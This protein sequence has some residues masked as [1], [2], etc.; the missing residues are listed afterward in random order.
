MK[1][2]CRGYLTSQL[3]SGDGVVASTSLLL[4]TVAAVCRHA[5]AVNNRKR[6][7][8]HVHPPRC[9]SSPLSVL[10]NPSVL[11]KSSAGSTNLVAVDHYLFL[12]DSQDR[13]FSTCLK[14][15]TKFMGFVFFSRLDFDLLDM[16]QDLDA[17]P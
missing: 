10:Q 6:A 4:S 14:V 9:W 7:S 13:K 16:S 2:F 1:F 3:A 15:S 12:I 17:P 5:A 8:L 11:T